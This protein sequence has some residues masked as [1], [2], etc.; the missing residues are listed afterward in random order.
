MSRTFITGDTHIPIDISKL[1]SENFPEGKTLSKED[2]VIVL[3][4]FGLIWSN[5]ETKEEKFWKEW[6]NRKPWTTLFL[7][8]NHENHILLSKLPIE[9]K[10]GGLVGRVSDSI[11]HLRRGEIFNINGNSFFCMGGAKS[12]DKQHRT[13]FISWWRE[14]EPLFAELD[15]GLNNLAVMGNEVDFILG[16]TGPISAVRKLGEICKTDF[17]DKEENLNLFFEHICGIVR[18]EKFYFGHYHV[19]ENIDGI[20]HCVFNDIIEI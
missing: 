17:G 12:V 18:F 1:N 15:R 20:F 8:G 6:L 11:F 3:G 2:V 9:E 19:D 5:E 10:F 16:H 4:D 7:D 13:E 14:E